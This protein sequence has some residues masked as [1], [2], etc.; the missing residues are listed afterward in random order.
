MKRRMRRK[1][2]F[3]ARGWLAKKR[4]WEILVTYATPSSREV[5]HSEVRLLLKGSV[6]GGDIIEGEENTQMDKSRAMT[7]EWELGSRA[8]RQLSLPGRAESSA[9]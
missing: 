1:H 4:N 7:I 8:P 5:V 9:Y 2:H 3:W 6:G